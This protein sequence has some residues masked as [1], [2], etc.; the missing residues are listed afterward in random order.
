MT[1]AWYSPRTLRNR[2]ARVHDSLGREALAGLAM[3][4]L[5]AVVAASAWADHLQ[6]AKSASQA[7]A[8]RG[9]AI[10]RPISLRAS[11]PLAPAA[12]VLPTS[13]D[14]PVLLTRLESLAIENRLAWAAADYRI[15]P[16]SEGEVASME[17]RMQFTGGY[18]QLRRMLSQALSQVPGLT[19]RQLS[20]TRAD[21]DTSD[22][23]AKVV[24]AILLADGPMAESGAASAPIRNAAA[25]GSAP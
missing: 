6:A 10:S 16:A 12:T 7:R 19:F 14:L 23:D 15:R 21:T 25:S 18:L 11:E 24:F 20:F 1:D 3:M 2:A 17:I 4:F 8:W 5:A 22:I 9:Q 13:A